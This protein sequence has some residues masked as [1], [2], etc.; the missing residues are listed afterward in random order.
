MRIR[1]GNDYVPYIFDILNQ[2]TNEAKNFS[3]YEF[4]L[5]KSFKELAKLVSQKE[6]STG[7]SRYCA[8]YDWKWRAKEDKTL[9]DLTLDGVDI[10]WNKQIS[11]WL[12]NIEAVKEMGSIY[13]L[14]GMDLNYAA[15]VIEI[16]FLTIN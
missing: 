3:N 4:K 12:R 11:G 9:V 16:N 6:N 15:V 13:T 7:L 5:F 8:G 14:P 1:A 2:N 10:Q